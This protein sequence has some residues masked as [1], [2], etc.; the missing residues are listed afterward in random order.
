LEEVGAS[1]EAI[2][3]GRTYPITHERLRMKDFNLII[4]QFLS[5]RCLSLAQVN[6]MLSGK[7]IISAPSCYDDNMYVELINNKVVKRALHT[8]MNH[9][10]DCTVRLV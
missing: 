6:Q 9:R 4:S 5:D 3:F 8:S 10:R 7:A 1:C 2:D